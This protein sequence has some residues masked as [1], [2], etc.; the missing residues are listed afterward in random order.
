MHRALE[1]S[2]SVSLAHMYLGV[3]FLREGRFDESIQEYA[4]AREV[5]PLSVIGARGLATAYLFRGD[6]TYALDLLR[7]A[8]E[9]GPALIVPPEIGVYLE[10][11]A[12]DEA[13]SYLERAKRDRPDDPMLIYSSGAIYA[14][15]HKRAEALQAIKD[16]EEMSGT[17][18]SQAHWIAKVYSVLNEKEQALSCSNAALRRAQSETFT[19]TNRFGDRFA[20]NLGSPHSCGEWGSRLKLRAS[21]TRFSFCAEKRARG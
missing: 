19:R 8:N 11:G 9:L 20:A 7:Q 1:L 3:L 2:P 16:L 18:L 6:S 12:F 4:K 13:S 10:T 14:A 21:N 5:D 17:S 15:Q